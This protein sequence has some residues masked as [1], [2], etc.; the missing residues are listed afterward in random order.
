M[1]LV[2]YN[3]EESDTERAPAQV[4]RSGAAA[5]AL[6]AVESDNDDDDDE[7][8]AGFDPKDAFGISRIS[9]QASA[10]T[11]STT[12]AKQVQAQSAPEVLVNVSSN[13]KT[14]RVVLPPKL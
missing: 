5:S 1:A 10:A 3:S 4:A 6:P 9:E 7:D 12:A 14:L 8:A 13:D 2:D 11:N